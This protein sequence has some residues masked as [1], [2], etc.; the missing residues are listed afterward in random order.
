MSFLAPLGLALAVLIPDI[1]EREILVSHT[2]EVMCPEALHAHTVP[3]P[4]FWRGPLATWPGAQRGTWI[5]RARPRWG[6]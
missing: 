3:F 1:E 4:S 2:T 5:R 6:W